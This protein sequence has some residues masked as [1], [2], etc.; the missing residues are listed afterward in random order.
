MTNEDKKFFEQ[1][2][3]GLENM[4]KGF[5]Y[6]YNIFCCE[7]AILISELGSKE[8]IVDFNKQ[9]WKKQKEMVPGLSDDHSGN[10]FGMACRLAISYLPQVK[11][12][13]RDD[14]INKILDK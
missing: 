14:K 7:Q 6:D 2:F 12:I 8:A 9:D 13:K 11:A 3:G 5:G 1:L 10:T 4:E